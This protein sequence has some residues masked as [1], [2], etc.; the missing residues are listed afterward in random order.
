[1]ARRPNGR[2]PETVRPQKFLSSSL[3]I[4]LRLDSELWLIY[5]HKPQ[6]Y[7][8]IE[9]LLISERPLVQSFQ[10]HLF[11]DFTAICDFNTF[12]FSDRVI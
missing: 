9:S 7:H 11:R 2:H 10:E 8:K 12:L 6:R 5:P 4:F 1:L 3:K